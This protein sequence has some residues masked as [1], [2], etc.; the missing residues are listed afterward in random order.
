[1]QITYVTTDNDF[2]AWQHDAKKGDA[3]CYYSYDTTRTNS[4]MLSKVRGM[5]ESRMAHAHHEIR[6]MADRAWR[7]GNGTEH[8]SSGFPQPTGKLA[9]I[10]RKVGLMCELLAVK[11]K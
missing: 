3:A 9:L 6:A 1:M 8:V 2:V 10:T 11:V 4:P 7:E 5:G